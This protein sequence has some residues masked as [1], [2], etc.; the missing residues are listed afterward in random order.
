MVQ[1]AQTAGQ[2]H[3]VPQLFECV[4]GQFSGEL[5]FEYI[6]SLF[7][8]NFGQSPHLHHKMGARTQAGLNGPGVPLLEPFPVAGFGHFQSGLV[9]RL[10]LKQLEMLP[11]DLADLLASGFGHAAQHASQGDRKGPQQHHHQHRDQHKRM[12]HAIPLSQ[13]QPKKP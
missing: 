1:G 4:I 10:S 3:P 13:P 6:A 8:A 2:I 9:H 11:T 7:G 12:Q 5:P